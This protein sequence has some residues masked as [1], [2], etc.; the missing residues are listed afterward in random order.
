MTDFR[1]KGRRTKSLKNGDKIDQNDKVKKIRL[2]AKNQNL[3]SKFQ[4]SRVYF[5]LN[6][7]GTTSTEGLANP[8]NSETQPT[9]PGFWRYFTKTNEVALSDC[10]KSERC[11][12]DPLTVAY[13][14]K[15]PDDTELSKTQTILN[16]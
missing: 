1:K 13:T 10:L 6:N 14:K 5:Y 8:M 15:K 4:S 12:N 3:K 9:H 2:Q 7:K 16:F 11:A